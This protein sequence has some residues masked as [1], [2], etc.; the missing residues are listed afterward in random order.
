[1]SIHSARLGDNEPPSPIAP[2]IAIGTGLSQ[3]DPL[4]VSPRRAAFLLDCGVTRVYEL[5]NSGELESYKEG[6][7]RKITMR[8]IRTRIERLLGAARA[9]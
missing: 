9:A 6:S 8:S 5:I 2:G 4:A 1:M 7:S 3:G